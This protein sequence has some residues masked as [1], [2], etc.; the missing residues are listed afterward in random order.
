MSQLN[1]AER[2]FLENATVIG[3]QRAIFGKLTS[4]GVP[5]RK[6]GEIADTTSGGTPDRNNSSY[7][8]GQT[9]WLKSGE[10]TDGLVTEIEETLSSE[11][12]AHSNA[13]VIPKGTLLIALYGATVGKTGILGVAAATNQ[14]VCA[15]TPK[16]NEVKTPFMYWFLRHKREDLLQS[17]FGGAQP[18]ISQRILRE[19]LVPLPSQTVQESISEFLSAVEQRMRGSKMELPELLPPLAEQRRVV[20]RIEA[21]AAQIHEART[22]RHQAAEEAEALLHN[23]AGEVFTRLEKRH[24]AREFGSFSPHVTSGPRNWAKHYEQS[25]PRFYRAQD[26][27][28]AGKVLEDAK[29][30]ITPPPGEQGRT[31]MLQHGD[32]MLVITGATVGRVNV[33]RKRLEQGFVSQHV[34][35]C[36]LPQSEVEPEFALWGLRGPIGQAQLLGQRYGQGKPGLNLTNIRSLSLPFPPLAEQRR[37]VAE[38]DALQAEVDALKRLQAETAAELDALLPAILDRAFKG[39]L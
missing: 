9:P 20:A 25:G 39:D 17:S 28:P 27:G 36:R 7:Y 29:V 18:N 15:I 24:K 33:Y 12:L 30:F 38:L 19:T 35:I 32:L 23:H 37:I 13:K 6:L 16:T 8:G 22:L 10:L 2:R 31:A 21:P 5:L 26:V 11:G 14:A 3:A 4:V 34:G 1:A